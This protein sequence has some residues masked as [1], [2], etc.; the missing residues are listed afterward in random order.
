MNIENLEFLKT[1]VMY[2]G[3]G[4][5]P[6]RDLVENIISGKKEFKI[7]YKKEFPDGKAVAAELNFRKSDTQDR[8]FF[9]NYDLFRRNED[10]HITKQRF[11]VELGNTY[12]FR[13]AVNMMEGRY[14]GKEHTTKAKEKYEAYSYIDFQD[15]DQYGNGKIKKLGSKNG[16]DLSKLLN[17]YPIKALKN[18]AELA[19]LQGSLKKGNRQSTIFIDAEGKDVTRYIEVDARYKKLNVYDENQKL[20]LLSQ[21]GSLDENLEAGKKK[22][23]SQNQNPEAENITSPEEEQNN[24]RRRRTQGV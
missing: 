5:I 17:E 22:A 4:E 9:N 18:E 7:D 13:E 16:F 6:E 10:G 1:Q 15:K 8:Y 24:R 21:K 20:M 2:T 23:E 12:T 14:V 3:F 11:R 19:A